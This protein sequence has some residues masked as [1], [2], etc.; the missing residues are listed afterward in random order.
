MKAPA[1]SRWIEH[2][3]FGYAR[4][5]DPQPRVSALVRILG[6]LLLA[7]GLARG[8]EAEKSATSR[9]SAL[10][11]A[12]T[13]APTLA[14]PA[15]QASASTSAPK[16]ASAPSPAYE[17]VP[18]ILPTESK[19]EVSGIAVLPD[20][21]AALS[22]RKG[23]VWILENPLDDP[24]QAR[25]RRFAG[26]LHEPLGLT[27]HDGALYTAQRSEITRIEDRDGDGVADVYET[28]AKGWG[29][30]GNYHEY[31]YGPVFDRD[32]PLAR[33]GDAPG[34]GRR[35][36]AGGRRAAFAVRAWSQPRR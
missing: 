7:A 10:A 29:L 31:A 5:R 27:W 1:T 11:I 22:L 2:R 15:T 20:G 30:S 23:E 19:F 26:A 16:S 14:P 28:A 32:G 3:N 12:P 35:T 33:L 17:R 4:R 8:A 24:A 18:Y 25:F 6:G 36:P 21:R 34:A 13:T 9:A